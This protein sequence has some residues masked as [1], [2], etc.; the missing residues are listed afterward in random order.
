MPV[1]STDIAT[2]RPILK[3]LS[4]FAQTVSQSAAAHTSPVTWEAGVRPATLR[5]HDALGIAQRLLRTGI[6]K[7]M[8]SKATTAFEWV[9]QST[10]ATSCDSE[11][12][13]TLC[14]VAQETS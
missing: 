13:Q 1:N 2:L 3:R 7:E 8:T 4:M 9:L 10:V 6:L 12:G 5:K 11:H 14:R